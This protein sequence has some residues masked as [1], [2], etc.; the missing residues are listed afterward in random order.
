MEGDVDVAVGLEIVE[1]GLAEGQ[2]E[3]D[4]AELLGSLR[5]R[6]HAADAE[7]GYAA[8]EPDHDLVLLIGDQNGL[9]EAG[10]VVAEF[11]RLMHA[12]E[13]GC[14]R[15]M[16]LE[17]IDAVFRLG[18]GKHR[19]EQ[20]DQ[21]VAVLLGHRVLRRRHCGDDRAHGGGAVGFLG[22]TRLKGIVMAA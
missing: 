13:R 20:A 17:L 18:G 9:A 19:P 2:A 22:N 8:L 1:E 6:H 10:E 11:G 12:Q 5:N 15:H 3:L 21:G 7:P 16:E 14:R 4:R